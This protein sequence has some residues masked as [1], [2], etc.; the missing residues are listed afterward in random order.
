MVKNLNANDPKMSE[1]REATGVLKL[2][3]GSTLIGIV[4]ACGGGELQV[5]IKI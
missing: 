4:V 5:K 3:N 1:L 2:A